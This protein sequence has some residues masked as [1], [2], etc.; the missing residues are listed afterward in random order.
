MV[1]K[2]AKMFITNLE[3]AIKNK[4]IQYNQP[5]SLAF[6]VFDLDYKKAILAHEKADVLTPSFYVVD[7]NKTTAHCCYVLENPVHRN[8]HSKQSPQRLFAT[9][10]E[11]YG[12]R[13]KADPGY[14]GLIMKSP[15]FEQEHHFYAPEETP[16]TV[17]LWEM[18]E[19]IDFGKYNAQQAKKRATARAT[20]LEDAYSESRNVMVFDMLRKWAYSEIRNYW[21]T[22]YKQWEKACF[23]QIQRIWA[24]VSVKYD[25][26]HP[27][28]ISEMKAS[29]KSVA[30]WT[31]KNTTQSGFQTYVE[32]THLPH[33]QSARGKKSGI[34]R[35]AL[36]S[37]KREQA[38]E[39][40]NGGMKQKT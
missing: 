11:V 2:G 13:L 1:G 23:E 4:Y 6:M 31:W 21:Q 18:A 17:N 35:L 9:I 22:D 15:W 5:N 10:E 34:A 40:S 7:K 26:S 37:D 32:L 3:K 14:S 16:T 36:S 25:K 8:E 27:Y 38:I 39:L 30:K 33:Q 12:E 19:F 29:A 28:L 24:G 20:A